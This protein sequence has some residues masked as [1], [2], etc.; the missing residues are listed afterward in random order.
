VKA[1]S[2]YEIITADYSQFELR[3]FAERAGETLMIESYQRRHSLIEEIRSLSGELG[4]TQWQAAHLADLK[5]GLPGEFDKAEDFLAPTLDTLKISPALIKQIEGLHGELQKTDLHRV[6]ASKVFGKALE[7]VTGADR[8]IGKIINFM[9][10]Y[11]GG[12]RRLMEQL[13][14]DGIKVDFHEAHRMVEEYHK[15]F[16]Q[17]SAYIKAM[18]QTVLLY[19][20]TETIAGR[21]RL[22]HLEGDPR[23]SDYQRIKSSYERQA[24]NFSI[25]GVNADVTKRAMSWIHRAFALQSL[26][27]NLGAVES[28]PLGYHRAPALG[29]GHPQLLISVHDE[30]VSLAPKEQAIGCAKLMERLMIEAAR[31][32]LKKVPIE[33]G[34]AIDSV[35]KK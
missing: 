27:G 23:S 17:G 32:D 26:T 11:G 29:E 22:Y 33:V 34:L 4:V 5:G 24:V 15:A 9:L 12:A 2:G 14:L 35:W 30:I 10:L 7:E 20:R 13:I 16:K 31:C 1:P 6:T 25:Q 19:G 21:R 3:A 8:K 28:I 18:Q